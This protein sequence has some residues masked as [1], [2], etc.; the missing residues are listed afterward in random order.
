M[1]ARPVIQD[2]WYQTRTVE[3]TEEAL[4]TKTGG[5]LIVQPTGTGKTVSAVKL[6]KNREPNKDGRVTFL[7]PFRE[8]VHQTADKVAEME[9]D[10][11]IVMAGHKYHPTK[12]IQVASV[13]TMRSWVKRGK[14]KMDDSTTL[15]VDEAHR[16]M[17]KTHQ[18]LI[19]RA[20]DDGAE[21]IGLT[22]T[23]I[24]SDGVGMGHSYNHMVMELTMVQAIKEGWLVQPDY[25][26]AFV[27]DLS[28]VS[29]KGGDF[30]EV[31]LERIMNQE[32][33]VG[34]IVSN[35]LENA[36]GLRTLAFASTVA[37]SIAIQ[38]EFAKVGVQ[39]VHIDGTTKGRIRD[40]AIRD[41]R[42]GRIQGIVN[43]AVFTEGTDIPS[44]QCIIDAGATKSLGR[45]NQKLGRGGRPI[46]ADGFD[47]DTVEGR[48]AAI[49]ASDKP[50]FLV[51]DHAGNY[52]RN[53]RIDRNIPWELT[54]G[55][56]IEE[57]E[58]EQ[59]EKQVVQFT[60]AD[61]GKV[62]SRQMYCPN[63]G[64]RIKK[65]GKMKDYLDA[66][67]VKLT[68][69]QFA[70]IEETITWRDKRNFYLEALYW[71]RTPHKKKRDEQGQPLP[72]RSDG[73]AAH[74]FKQKFG[75]WP[76]DEWHRSHRPIKPTTETLNYI[77]SR[78][79]AWAKSQK[80]GPQSQ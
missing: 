16:S 56:E 60:C 19:Q 73:F 62:F 29:I 30:S 20:L 46:Y 7:A 23:P 49:A 36:R 13:A 50:R 77:R 78:N 80:N 48:L 69:E 44:L 35:W 28:G 68:G 70:K 32:V 41:L 21:V 47:I 39:F 51:F 4:A 9:M 10:P 45:H 42:L 25:R 67:L 34:D 65:V 24:R 8:I 61:C 26:V 5:V 76:E 63:C 22:A 71:C 57:K 79:I 12:G 75:E 17:S 2:R 74:L 64:L 53:G 18:W 54:R 66:E 52:Y 27:P 1:N 59:R 11:G 14:I 72:N 38:H 15:M 33:L 3:R 40:D 43:C 58:K 31:D 55:K 37:H 6:I